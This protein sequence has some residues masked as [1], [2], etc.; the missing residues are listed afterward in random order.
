MAPR[1]GI[2]AATLLRHAL[3]QAFEA[4]PSELARVIQAGLRNP[5][6]ALGYVEF[7]AKLNGEMRRRPLGGHN[8]APVIVIGAGAKA[9]AKDHSKCGDDQMLVALGEI[10]EP[11]AV[12]SG[13]HFPAD[14]VRNCFQPDG[15]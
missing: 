2:A 9:I 10:S 11:W 5:H 7:I 3:A 8:H 15:W 1:L 4:S 14:R 13:R 12:P 6:L